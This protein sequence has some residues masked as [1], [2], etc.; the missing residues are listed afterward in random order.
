[1]EH[2]RLEPE[3]LAAQA[4]ADA[5]GEVSRV[6]VALRAAR[7]AAREGNL[8]K[9]RAQER[10]ARRYV[11]RTQAALAEVLKQLDRIEHVTDR[12]GRK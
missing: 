7:D 11:E 12:K 2:D 1:M 10:A 9:T 5:F 3:H 6:T 8:H 4:A